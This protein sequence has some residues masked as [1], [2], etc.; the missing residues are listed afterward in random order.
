[1]GLRED[2][3]C[4]ECQGPWELFGAVCVCGGMVD[5]DREVTKWRQPFQ[6]F[7]YN[8]WEGADSRE[9][10]SAPGREMDKEGAQALNGVGVIQ[11]CA[12]HSGL[13]S[14]SA[15]GPREGCVPPRKEAGGGLL[16]HGLMLVI[17]NSLGPPAP[18]PNAVGGRER[19]E[20][21]VQLPLINHPNCSDFPK[22]TCVIPLLAS[23]RAVAWA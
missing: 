19:A 3:V 20:T 21:Q 6:E 5:S 4:A 22:Y 11:V 18:T 17:L 9:P 10:P 7:P 1:M 12:H 16:I 23:A 14:G 2:G 15:S 8:R 13:C